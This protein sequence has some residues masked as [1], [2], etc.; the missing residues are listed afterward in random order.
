MQKLNH[1]HVI[2]RGIVSGIYQHED[3]CDISLI[4]KELIKRFRP[5]FLFTLGYASK[6]VTGQVGKDKFAKIIARMCRA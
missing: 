1:L 4:L 3:V 2:R 5:F 6:A